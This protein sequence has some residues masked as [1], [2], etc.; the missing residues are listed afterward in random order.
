MRRVYFNFANHV[1][2]QFGKIQRDP[3]IDPFPRIS[4]ERIDFSKSR[5]GHPLDPGSWT[6]ELR[7]EAYRAI[8]CWFL[9][10]ARLETREQTSPATRCIYNAIFL[11]NGTSSDIAIERADPR[12][13]DTSRIGMSGEPIKTESN[14]LPFGPRPRLMKIPIVNRAG[15]APQKFSA[16]VSRPRAAFHCRTY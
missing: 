8:P 9:P 15:F 14:I 7:K 2:R 3:K 13:S 16:P 1:Q 6:R 5:G 11:L 10:G 12:F 4:G